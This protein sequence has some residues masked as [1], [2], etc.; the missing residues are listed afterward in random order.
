MSENK[1]NSSP[2][3]LLISLLIVLFSVV[4]REKEKNIPEGSISSPAISA[5][6]ISGIQAIPGPAMSIPGISIHWI[7]SFNGMSFQDCNSDGGLIANKQLFSHFCS[8]R[9]KFLSD[10]P[11][12]RLTFLQ[13]I[14]GQEK[15]DDP[16]PT[17]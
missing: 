15:G 1:R 14:P 5:A 6:N 8:C 7:H 9:L 13:K 16:L 17:A 2:V 10:K 12:I 4:H 3:I 11:V